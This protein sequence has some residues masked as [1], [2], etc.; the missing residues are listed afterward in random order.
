MG[1]LNLNVEASF[2]KEE[3]KGSCGAVLRINSG[4]TFLSA[5]GPIPNFPNSKTA[6]AVAGLQGIK[7]ILSIS[8][9]PVHV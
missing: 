5:W 3:K 2:V 4:N 9:K 1:W 8:A 7:S 6:E